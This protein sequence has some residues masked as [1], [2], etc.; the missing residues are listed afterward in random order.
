MQ[1]RI[2]TVGG[3]VLAAAAIFGCYDFHLAGPEDPP[4]APNRLVSVVVEY[5]QDRACANV[6]AQ[7]D[8][9]VFFTGTWMVGGAAF[10]LQRDPTGL[11]W[12]GTALAVPAN[13]PPSG[14]PYRVNVLD[15]HLLFTPTRGVSGR[16]IVVGGQAVHQLDDQGT[17]VE[18]AL[19]YI[20]LDG[21]GH[22]PL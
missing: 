21:Q 12:R 5:R 3:I 11:V 15:P 7:C 19:V 8:G 2:A 4:P 17:T 20:D 16:N 9:Q 6:P 13:F 14:E 22:N 18:A 10:P 1:S